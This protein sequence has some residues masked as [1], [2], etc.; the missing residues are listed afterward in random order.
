M[1][2]Q[3]RKHSKEEFYPVY[4]KWIEEHRFPFLNYDILP[5]NFFVCY[6]DELPIY[7][8]PLWWT[9][10]KICI[11]AFAVSNRSVNYKKKV[12]GLDYLIEQ[13]CGYAK[14]KKLLSIYTTTTTTQVIDSLTKNGFTHGDLDSSQFFKL[15]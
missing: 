11:I 2:F 15:L 4:S 10:S 13:I 5:N 1:D 8:M 12:G 9:D 7:A 3:V 14:R 6:Q